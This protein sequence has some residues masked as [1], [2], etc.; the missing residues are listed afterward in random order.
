VA[1]VTVVLV[2]AAAAGVAAG[3]RPGA[4]ARV[5]LGGWPLLVG[6]GVCQLAGM[7][8]SRAADS[9]AA[10]AIGSVV[11]V[12]LLTGFLLSNTRLP[13]I[14]LVAL[15][16]L[17]NAVVIAANDAMPV[18]RWAADRVGIDLSGI[19]AGL[20]ARH[21]VAGAGTSLRLLGDVIPVAIPGWPEVVSP[22][23][24]LVAAGLGLLLLSAL[25]WPQTGRGQAEGGNAATGTPEDAVRDT[26]RASASTTRGS[27]S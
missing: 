5:P 8:V 25:L 12:I 7:L 2:L 14:P 21:A 17:L 24:V 1:L 19:A 15:G 23:D 11:A 22:G 3:G 18:S 9:A 16:L 20:D 26:T 27:Y 6:A 4:L 10:Y 13:G